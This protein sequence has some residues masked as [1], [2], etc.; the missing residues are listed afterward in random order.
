[1]SKNSNT[2]LYIGLAAAAGA[3]LLLKSKSTAAVTTPGNTSVYNATGGYPYAI[4][5][6]A[7]PVP[8]TWNFQYYLQWIYPAMIKA[9]PNV[10]NSNYQLT[11]AELQQ[12]Y[13]SYPDLQGW[14]PTVVPH[15]FPDQ[16]TALQSHWTHNAVAE[17]R[18]FMPFLPTSTKGYTPPPANS[19]SSGG[20]PWYS[21]A[22]SI[23]GS[24]IALAGRDEFDN[25]VQS[26]ALMSVP[27]LNDYDVE[28]LITGSAIGLE[29]LPFY[30]GQPGGIALQAEDRIKSALTQ[31]TRGYGS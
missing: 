1:M 12:Y 5:P 3:F 28:I 11:P 2:G 30:Y 25:P 14:I 4:L 13:A 23:A 22:L 7:P 19:N 26:V 17:S 8:S 9:N 21:T 18:S 15:N 10:Q 24:V 27:K 16:N 29:L 6:G 31:Y 20:T